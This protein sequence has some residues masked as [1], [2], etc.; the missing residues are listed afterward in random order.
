MGLRILV[1]EDNL[2]VLRMMRD[3]LEHLGHEVLVA[4]RVDEALQQ[5]ERMPELALVDIE[6]PGG[7]GVELL[8]QVR[9]AD[10]SARLPMVAVTAHSDP[11]D[12]DR[13]LALGFDAF[14]GK[15]IDIRRLGRLVTEWSTLGGR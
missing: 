13:I 7:G 2:V 14:A 10:P 3:V 4:T 5:L 1:V 15:P 9:A 8:R 12:Q 11:D 6:I